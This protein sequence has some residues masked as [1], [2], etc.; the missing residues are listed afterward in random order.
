METSKYSKFYEAREILEDIIEKDLL[1][2]VEDNEILCEYPLAC[3]ILGK[4]Y[5]QN[6]AI[7]NIKTGTS[8][9]DLIELQEDEN[10]IRSSSEDCGEIDEEE[11]V[12]LS[13]SYNPSSFGLS[14]S[15]TKNVKKIRIVPTAARYKRISEQEAQSEWGF[16]D[17][18][19]SKNNFW[20]R[21]PLCLES[22]TLDVT[23][24][25]AGRVK[26]IWIY[27]NE[28]SLRIILHKIYEDDGSKTIS[29]TMVNEWK[30]DDD[31]DKKNDKDN[32]HAF[33]QPSISVESLK[34][35]TFRDVRR[36]I[37]LTQ[38]EEIAELELLYSKNG[39]YASGHGCAVD[40]DIEDTEVIRVYT[41][42]LPR[43]ELRQMMPAA[44]FKHDVLQMKYLCTSQKEDVLHGLTLLTDGY[45]E[46]INNLDINALNKKH[47]SAAK[48]N[49]KK[50][51]STLE[52]LRASI[53][54]LEDDTAF[55]AFQLANYA[56]YLQWQQKLKGDNDEE[57]INDEKIKWFPFQLAFFLQEVVSIVNPTGKNRKAVDLLWFPTGGGKTEAYLGIAAFTIFYRR[58]QYG[59]SGN[60]VTV[61][62]RYTLRLLTYQQFERAAKVICAC[63]IIR[64][65]LKN[66]FEY[67]LGD[68]IGIG[69]W[70]GSALTPN[71]ISDAKMYLDKKKAGKEPES[72]LTNPVQLRKCPW[73]GCTIEEKDYIPNT[74]EKGKER[75][76]IRCPDEK[77]VFHG[78]LPVYLIDQEIYNF[79]PSFIVATIDKFAQ[80]ALKFD[81]TTLFGHYKGLL[82]PDLIIQDE[83]HLISGPLGTITGLYEAGI[84]KICERNG[85]YP[86]IIASTATIRNAKEQIRSLY[87]STY[88]QFPPQGI[89]IDDSFFAEQS[90]PDLKPARLYLGC[91]GIGCS[92]TTMMIRVMTSLLY[93]SRYLSEQKAFNDKVIDNFWTITG[94]FNTLRELGGAIIRVIDD[95][96][97][98]FSYLKTTKFAHVYPLKHAKK[99]Y[100]KYKELTSREK[101]ENI[102]DIIQNQLT[103][104]YKSDGST[105]P[106]DFLLSSN[107]I[108]VGVDV[109]RLGTMVVVGQPKTTSEYIQATSRV[110]RDNPGLV[111]ATYNQSKSRDR[112]H[113]ESFRQYHQMF[114]RYVEATSVTPFADRARDRALQALYVVLC[115]N[116]IRELAEDNDAKKFSPSNPELEKIRKYILDYVK[117]VD[118]D[119]YNHVECELDEI[120]RIWAKKASSHEKLEYKNA[121]RKDPSTGK[122]KVIDGLFDP[123]Y[124]ENSRF[125][126]LNTMRSVETIVKVSIKE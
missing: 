25:V 36:N 32:E 19:F 60:G 62:M 81:T 64:R 18:K 16:E 49:I 2:P 92:A 52:T 105:H 23:E 80:L 14:F 45:E 7:S 119:E 3:Y 35:G 85:V 118:G 104:E 48:R 94:Y 117:E 11:G 22:Y 61:I 91:M 13:Y 46:W 21:E 87:N 88:T 79:T 70:V 65:I 82:P 116:L 95:I 73:C 83:L 102:G 33:F 53:K 5:P 44:K 50:C 123:D 15:I 126:I 69:L 12:T 4:L 9:E 47:R 100:D 120:E 68:E 29:V 115:R 76:I 90:T 59:S 98:R 96:Q 28:L 56:M 121:I 103:T 72:N 89:D 57:E 55:E 97:D 51:C 108:S 31:K 99:R 10:Q 110:G 38:N 43:Y 1:G 113:Y 27:K 93:A 17:G 84:R 63:E 124:K 26:K 74:T 107:M 122:V 8:K 77:C 109:G 66:K 71:K 106:F 20:K 40:W 30:S 24:L 114:Y 101:S 6:S 111:I 39:N 54:A 112:S 58:L 41:A 75:M 125:R 78:G 37:D 34:K 86:K 42:F 67:N